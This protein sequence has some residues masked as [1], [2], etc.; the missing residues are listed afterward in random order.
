MRVLGSACRKAAAASK[1]GDLVAAVKAWGQA[2]AL[3]P[4]PYDVKLA[5]C[6]TKLAK[7]QA[8][9]AARKQAAEAAL[10]QQ[11]QQEAEAQRRAA[12]LERQQAEAEERRA[13]EAAA[14]AAEEA[15]RAEEQAQRQ[16][17]GG[18]AKGGGRQTG[19]MGTNEGQ[20]RQLRGERP[21]ITMGIPSSVPS[22]LWHMQ[23]VALV[24]CL[25][26]LFLVVWGCF[27]AKRRV[28]LYVHFCGFHAIHARW[29]Q[30][31]S[32]QHLPTP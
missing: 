9:A 28:Q 5:A 26:P 12:E 22:H 6:H 4:G 1:R 14:A 18:Y 8:E 10:R 17:V 16:R 32:F 27:G 24:M 19:A 30:P 2:A 11:Q 25:G 23:H 31:H 7:R 3:V 15:R 13:A 21:L 29:R 20:N